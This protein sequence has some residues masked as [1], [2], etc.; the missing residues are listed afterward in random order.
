MPSRHV[1]QDLK[2]I[3]LL[4]CALL[5]ISFQPSFLPWCWSLTLLGLTG[6][7][8]REAGL[9]WAG[10][11]S[12]LSAACRI[13]GHAMCLSHHRC[14]A[15]LYVMHMNISS[16]LIILKANACESA[17]IRYRSR[18]AR[19]VIRINCPSSFT[20]SSF[21]AFITFKEIVFQ[22][23]LV[24]ESQLNWAVIQLLQK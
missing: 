4:R 7:R 22:L 3:N 5:E 15:A 8:E 10:A 14:T 17:A 20:R 13:K 23:S 18:S 6:P 16:V 1:R 24:D 11:I 2:H 12:Q 19:Y 21:T 9:A